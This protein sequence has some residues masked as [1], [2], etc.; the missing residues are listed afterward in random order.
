MSWGQPPDTAPFG[1][2]YSATI[3]FELARSSLGQLL[4]SASNKGVCGVLFGEDE[5]ALLTD[6]QRRFPRADILRGNRGLKQVAAQVAAVVEQPGTTTTLPLDMRGT[7]FQ[8]RVW[9]ALR[10]IAPG[11]TSSYAAVAKDIGQPTAMRAVAQAC[12]ANNLAVL[13]PCHRVV[14]SDG[15]LSGYHWGIDRKRELL[16]REARAAATKAGDA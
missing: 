1:S 15:S 13:V 14:R 9:Q 5:T 11:T 12:G 8:Q 7:A 2:G 16:A 3:R 6:L 10:Q 4:V